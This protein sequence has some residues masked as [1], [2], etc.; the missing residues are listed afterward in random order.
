MDGKE[1]RA[2]QVILLK[3]ELKKINNEY[4]NY[5]KQLQELGN[6]RGQ[7]QRKIIELI[8]EDD[9]ELAEKQYEEYLL[10]L[11][12]EDIQHWPDWKREKYNEEVAVC[13]GTEKF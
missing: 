2:E 12:K 1:K 10:A 9:E 11:V 7:I 13:T 5:Y 6:K 3:R 4:N 8:E